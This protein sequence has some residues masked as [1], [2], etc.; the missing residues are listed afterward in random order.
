ME[1]LEEEHKYIHNGEEYIS[2][3]TLLSEFFSKFEPYEVIENYY[4]YWQ[5][6]PNSPYFSKSKEEIKL[7]WE[8][9]TKLGT[10]LH[11]HIETYLKGKKVFNFGLKT[12]KINK[13]FS[14]FKR[15]LE[16][17]S[18]LEIFESEFIVFSEILKLAGTIDGV[19][20]NKDTGK[21]VLIDWK[22]V[23][24]I[25]KEGDYCKPPIER[26]RDCNY[27]KYALQLNFYRFLL[28]NF[29]DRE[30]EAMY[31]VQLHSDYENYI[32]YNIPFYQYETK[33]II[34]HY[35]KNGLYE[36]IIG[37]KNEKVEKISKDY[38][39]K[40]NVLEKQQPQSNQSCI[41]IRRGDK[42]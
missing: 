28:K 30:V 42:K 39:T 12:A 16:N 29:I 32:V 40:K 24:N 15:F 20:I 25:S 10:I 31:I 26:F 6:N 2:V 33:K 1:F 36:K 37:K 41:Y 34:K 14:H 35:L 13:E 7:M 5:N 27:Y 17:N 22:R 18:H 3:T 38:V 11:K 4:H 21:L 9:N 19:F 23:K 8:E